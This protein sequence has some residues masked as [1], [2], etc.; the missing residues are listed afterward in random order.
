MCMVGHIVQPV[1]H[2]HVSNID[3]IGNYYGLNNCLSRDHGHDHLCLNNCEYKLG[4]VP[5]PCTMSGAIA[6]GSHHLIICSIFFTF[7]VTSAQL[8]SIIR[9]VCIMVGIVSM[10]FSIFE[11]CCNTLPK[12]STRSI[13]SSMSVL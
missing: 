6:G 7:L 10:N 4:T 8:G 9:C 12:V 11:S 5:A 2:H 13:C 3:G 1:I